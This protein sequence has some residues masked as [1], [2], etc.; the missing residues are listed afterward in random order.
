MTNRTIVF[1]SILSEVIAGYIEEKRAVGYK[2]KKGSSLLKQF[3]T[4]V[5][6]ETL[7]DIKLPKELVLLWTKKRNNET[8]STRNGRI[9][10][11]RGLA[12]YMVRLGYDAYIFPASSVSIERY[13]YVPYIFSKVELS[14]ILSVC[15]N[16]PISNVSPN[17]HLILPLLFRVLYGCGLRISEALN[18]RLKDVDLNQGTLFIKDTKFGKERKIPMAE[19]LTRHC[20]V[21][22]EKVHQLFSNDTFLF[23][24]PF[25]GRYKESTIY[26]LFRQILWKAGISHS[27]KGPRLHDLRHTFAV[28]CL[29]KWVLNEEDI[30]NLLPYL[31]AFLGHVDLRGTQH[32]LR[33]TADLY[34]KII[35]S[36]EQ[37]FS[38]LIPEVAF[39]ETD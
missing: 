6:N 31:S 34:P 38:S 4:L 24:S 37:N 28:H 33:L 16:Y 29:K 22:V 15:D 21:Y 12:T 20:S 26:K 7:S 17:K 9:S 11:I 19:T 30:T 3:D 27:G 1:Q 14:N 23:P 13:S 10:I 18:L 35:D 8:A 2:Y 5:I 39:D 25:G 32:Y 36:V